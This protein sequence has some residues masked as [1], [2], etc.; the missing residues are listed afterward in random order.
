[1]NM[2]NH[3]MPKRILVVDDEEAVRKS[4]SLAFKKLPYELEFAENGKIAIEMFDSGA[5]DLIYLDLKM[6]EMNG[7]DTLKAIR[8]RDKEIPIY[9]VTAFHKEFFDEL[10]EA[11]KSKL[12][13][14]LLMKPVGRDQIIAVTKGILEGGEVLEGTSNV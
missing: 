8:K 7:V 14:D 9:I 1:M 4:F 12:D 10:A 13:F 2:E 11:R 3:Q 5:Y 6:P